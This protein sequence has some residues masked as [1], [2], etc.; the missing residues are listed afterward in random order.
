M[1][2]VKPLNDLDQDKGKKIA[3]AC[4]TQISTTV[5]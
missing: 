5:V 4:F 2:L 3:F 1:T